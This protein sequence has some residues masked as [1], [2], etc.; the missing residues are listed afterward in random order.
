M[1]CPDER[2]PRARAIIMPVYCQLAGVAC[3]RCRACMLAATAASAIG[4]EP[5]DDIGRSAR[6]VLWRDPCATA[7]DVADLVMS[8]REA[9]HRRGR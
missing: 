9:R 4:Q 6:F 7:R 1:T 2:E 3:G 5:G 8:R